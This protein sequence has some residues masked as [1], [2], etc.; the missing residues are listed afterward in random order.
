MTRARTLYRIS[1]PVLRADRWLPG[2]E[3]VFLNQKLAVRLGAVLPDFDASQDVLIRLSR[4]TAIG[5]AISRASRNSWRLHGAADV[6]RPDLDAPAEMGQFQHRHYAIKR[7]RTGA[8]MVVTSCRLETMTGQ[9]IVI[10]TGRYFPLTRSAAGIP[11]R[12]R[13]VVQHRNGTPAE[14]VLTL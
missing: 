12:A 11:T 8:D 9:T 3:V 2:A 10:D 14:L 7:P 1:V 6:C 4:H 13:C 5:P